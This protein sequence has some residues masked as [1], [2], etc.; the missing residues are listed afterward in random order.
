MYM[1]NK[2]KLNNK[3]NIILVEV[4]RIQLREN[5]REE[6]GKKNRREIEW[7][8]QEIRGEHNLSS[9][10]GDCD[11]EIWDVQLRFIQRSSRIS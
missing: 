2:N 10:R 1:K 5:K 6:I 8:D 4:Y 9:S 7:I 11:W 3:Q